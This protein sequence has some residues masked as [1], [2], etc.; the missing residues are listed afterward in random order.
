LAVW[1]KRVAL[2]HLGGLRRGAPAVLALGLVAA[3]LSCGDS[4]S[5]TVTTTPTPT[6]RYVLPGRSFSGFQ[7]DSWASIEVVVNQRGALDITV[8]WTYP[9]TWMYVYF[10][11]T[12]CGWAQ[13]YRRT[14]PFML[15]SETKDPKPRILYTETLDPGTYYVFVY[16][17]PR[18][19]ST[20]TGSDNTE[21]VSIQIGLTPS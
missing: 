2:R 1:E 19:P 3:L 5:P 6:P 7:T 4:A 14:C 12:D 17:V 15:S 9:D 16:N 21:A 18:H 8:D 11:R 20:G 10:G 13:L